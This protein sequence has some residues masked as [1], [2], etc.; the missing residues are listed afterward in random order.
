MT[1]WPHKACN[2]MKESFDV[3]RTFLDSLSDEELLSMYYISLYTEESMI[4]SRGLIQ[5]LIADGGILK[6][7]NTYRYGDDPDDENMQ[8][9]GRTVV[10]ILILRNLLD[11]DVE[12]NAVSI[13]MSKF[14]RQLVLF[15]VEES[16]KVETIIRSGD[17]FLVL[18]NCRG[19]REVPSDF[20]QMRSLEVVDIRGCGLLVVPPQFH[21]LPCLRRLLCSFK[22]L[23]VDVDNMA[24]RFCLEVSKCLHLRELVVEVEDGVKEELFYQLIRACDTVLMAA[25]TT[26]EYGLN[27]SIVMTPNP[28]SATIDTLIVEALHI[29][30]DG[31]FSHLPVVDRD[32]NV[33]AVFDVLIQL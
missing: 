4:F 12:Q 1:I 22:R 2:A 31:F 11:G 29:M 20:G 18:R 10:N 3:F 6:P 14:V 30:N 17:R 27:S 26:L 7:H 33:V 24:T 16:R 5:N 32:G 13:S 15:N 19:L 8:I 28:Q 9:Y 25:K 23:G 21:T